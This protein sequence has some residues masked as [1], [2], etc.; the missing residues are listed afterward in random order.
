[1]AQT[2]KNV[3]GTAA[4]RTASNPCGHGRHWAAGTVQYSA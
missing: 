3:S 2:V 4:A 1:L